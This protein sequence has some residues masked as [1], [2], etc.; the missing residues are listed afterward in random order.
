MEEFRLM[1]K[2]LSTILILAAALPCVLC[3]C[4]FETDFSM[5]EVVSISPADGATG[6]SRDTSIDVVFSKEMDTNKTSNEFSLDSD[7]GRVEGYFT[8]SPDGKR[9]SFK[10]AVTSARRRFTAYR[11]FLRGGH[12]RQRPQESHVSI[13]S[14]SAD[15]APP[16]LISFAPANDSAVAPDAVISLVFSEAIDLNSLYGG[17]SI[18]PQLEGRYSWD[19]SHSLITFTPL[20]PM[21]FGTTYAVTVNTDIRDASGNRLP[22]AEFF[23]F[24]VGD[25]FTKPTLAVSQPPSSGPWSEDIENQGVEKG[26][27][28]VIL[29]SERIA[30]SELRSAIAISPAASF[31]ID[32]DA[33]HT[34]ACLKFLEPLESEAHYTLRISPTIRDMQNNPLA[35]E[36]RFH[37]L[38]N[39]PYSIAPRITS[40]T[41]PR[42]PGGWVP[43]ETQPLS[44]ELSPSG[45]PWYPDV[46]IHFSTRMNPTS[47]VITVDRVIGTGTT[48]RVTGPDWPDTPPDPKLGVYEFDL[49]GVMAGNVYKITIKGGAGGSGT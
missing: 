38:T 12:T 25:D 20:Y 37:F 35:K 9:L 36:Y 2:I 29:F 13:F 22:D 16:R 23:N 33:G 41:D 8:W 32:T 5:P 21:P 27:D 39:G 31:Y 28:I 11:C 6:V 17:V 1:N 48:P 24:T 7:A 45:E 44:F 40:I 30:V 47:L 3:R 14:V 43:G 42:I 19:P 15:L 34:T 4:D 26:G 46:R 10:P 49:T 18:S